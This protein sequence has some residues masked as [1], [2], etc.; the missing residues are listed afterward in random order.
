VL[1]LGLTPRGTA[2]VEV[3]NAIGAVTFDP[4]IFRYA[5]QVPSDEPML[6]IARDGGGHKLACFSAPAMEPGR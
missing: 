2:S 4:R 1:L 5:A 6:A 3:P